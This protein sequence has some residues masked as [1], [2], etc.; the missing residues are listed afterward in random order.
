MP[1]CV[2]LFLC[3]VLYNDIA[4]NYKMER[5]TCV[6]GIAPTIVGLDPPPP[7]VGSLESAEPK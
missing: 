4:I 2:L 5:I 6:A 3:T 7:N 1:K